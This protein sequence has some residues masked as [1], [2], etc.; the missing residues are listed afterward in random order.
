MNKQKVL[1]KGCKQPI[2]VKTATK[3][4]GYSRQCLGKV[5]TKMII[6]GTTEPSAEEIRFYLH[7]THLK[8][9]KIYYYKEFIRIWA[10]SGD[11]ENA[12]KYYLAYLEKLE[13]V[14]FDL[15]LTSDQYSQ[16]YKPYAEVVA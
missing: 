10:L 16:L 14:V 13:T 6:T 2:L 3:Y 11:P 1:C 12:R 7:K 5:Q 9:P 8:F 4:Q 15:T